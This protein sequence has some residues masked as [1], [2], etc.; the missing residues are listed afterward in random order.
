MTPIGLSRENI[1]YLFSI[2]LHIYL[3]ISKK[4]T[5]FAPILFERRLCLHN[6]STLFTVS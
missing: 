2:K 6:L 5:T 3:H 4:S 1:R